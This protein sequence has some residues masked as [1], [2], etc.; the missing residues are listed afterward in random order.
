MSSPSKP[1]YYH[2]SGVTY[3]WEEDCSKNK[4]P[5]PGWHKDSFQPRGREQW[6]HI[7]GKKIVQKTNIPIPVGKKIASNQGAGNNV[8]SAKKNSSS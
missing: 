7:I 6:L 1:Y 3:H 2:A 8:K 4:Y 5:D